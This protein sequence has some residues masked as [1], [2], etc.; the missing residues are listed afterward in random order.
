MS[1]LNELLPERHRIEDLTY[2]KNEQLGL[3]LMDRKAIFDLYCRSANGER[4]IVELQKAKQNYFKD[5]SVFYSSFPIR[6]QA[7]RGDWNF[8]L[9]AVYTIGV[10]DFIFDDNKDNAQLLSSSRFRHLGHI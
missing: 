3:D 8:R 5:R 2:T 1:F 9:E 7:Q 10:L 4:F 6:E